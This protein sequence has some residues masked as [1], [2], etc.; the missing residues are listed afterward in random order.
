MYDYQSYGTRIML[1]MTF[2]CREL[3]LTVDWSQVNKEDYLFAMERS[4][5]RDKEIKAL[6]KAALTTKVTDR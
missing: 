5:V 4:V 3:N 2:S 1:S 6:L